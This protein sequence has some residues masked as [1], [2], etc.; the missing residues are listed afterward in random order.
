MMF[1]LAGALRGFNNQLLAGLKFMG[2]MSPGNIVAAASSQIYSF[3]AILN[4]FYAFEGRV[5]GLIAYLLYLVA[6]KKMVIHIFLSKVFSIIRSQTSW[7]FISFKLVCSSWFGNLKFLPQ[8]CSEQLQAFKQQ[9]I[10]E[11]RSPDSAAP[12]YKI[13]IY[14]QIAKNA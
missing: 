4:K 11:A 1:L 6:R 8:R 14:R 7:F 3:V 10:C 12:K 2:K 5:V 13:P 9:L